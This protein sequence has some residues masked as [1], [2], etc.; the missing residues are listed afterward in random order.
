[1][2]EGK[3]EE[4]GAYWPNIP[5]T[6]SMKVGTTYP[7]KNLS[8]C[9]GGCKFPITTMGGSVSPPS[10]GHYA[11]CPHPIGAFFGAFKSGSA[12]Q[13]HVIKNS[14]TQ[15][16]CTYTGTQ[17]QMGD[18]FHID[19]YYVVRVTTIP[20]LGYKGIITIVFKEDKNTLFHS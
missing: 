5:S 11:E 17:E 2:C 1:M 14:V 18:C 13:H 15:P 8:L 20:Y 7:E 12:T 9:I 4:M 19:G 16:M 10:I 6:S 3:Q